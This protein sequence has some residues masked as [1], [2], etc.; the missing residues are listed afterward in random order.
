MTQ[1]HCCKYFGNKICLNYIKIKR[2]LQPI[3][4]GINPDV[5]AKHR[6][7][8]QTMCDD[9]VSAMC[10]MIDTSVSERRSSDEPL[11]QEVIQHITFAQAKCEMFHGCGE[12]LEVGSLFMLVHAQL[13]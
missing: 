9:F 11:V 1:P 13:N 8:L 6:S 7:Y 5:D 10:K 2:R 4:S 12:P 3:L